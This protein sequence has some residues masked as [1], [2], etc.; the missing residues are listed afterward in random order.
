M[1]L[2]NIENLSFKYEDSKDYIIKNLDFS[3]EKGKFISILGS[4]GCGKTT[5][6]KILAGLQGDS[7]IKLPISYM[8]QRDSLLPWRTALENICLPL[9]VEKKLPKKVY[10]EKAL[11]LLKKLNL[12]NYKS[13]LPKN[14][15]G[16][17]KQRIAFA[18]TLIKDSDI[19]LLDEPF[20][21]LDAI[22]KIE[23]REW[24]KNILDSLNKT[25]ILIT[26][27][28]EEAIFLSD[29]ILVV[30]NTPIEDFIHF[31]VSEYSNRELL[32]NSILEIIRS[33]QK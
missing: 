9:E 29:E 30:K 2:F 18:R 25:S 22:S 8:P 26:H 5:L 16:G 10:K 7:P 1:K 32:K 14:L 6:L 13:Y 23:I 24:V 28:V 12:E 11:E 27:D 15:S 31:K 21:A 20:S 17:M 33:S 3:M 4:S 19:F